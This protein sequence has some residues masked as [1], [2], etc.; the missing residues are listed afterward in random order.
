MHLLPTCHLNT[1]EAPKKAFSTSPALLPSQAARESLMRAS[2][3]QRHQGKHNRTESVF[4]THRND[5]S[6]LQVI[7][8][9]CQRFAPANPYDEPHMY[10]WRYHN[11][12]N[13]AFRWAWRHSLF[14]LGAV[15]QR[16]EVDVPVQLHALLAQ[17]HPDGLAAV[18]QVLT[19]LPSLPPGTGVH[20]WLAVSLVPQQHLHQHPKSWH[21]KIWKYYHS[22][23]KA[24][25]RALRDLIVPEPGPCSVGEGV[26]EDRSQ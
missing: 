23:N 2:R 6:A 26:A 7:C 19:H 8:G 12:F 10:G 9:A 20:Q 11:L 15:P 24:R 22:P 25:V 14:K 18:L 4:R 13:K 16:D 21:H 1:R 3:S 5:T 17:R